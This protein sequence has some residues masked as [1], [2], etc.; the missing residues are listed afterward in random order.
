VV[1]FF[2]YC[3]NLTIGSSK[4]ATRR[5]TTLVYKNASSLPTN[6]LIKENQT[7]FTPDPPLV[8]FHNN[9]ANT[10]GGVLFAYNCTID[11][12]ITN[13]HFVQNHAL[14]AGGAMAIFHSKLNMNTIK[15]STVSSLNLFRGN[16]G[17]VV[18]HHSYIVSFPL[19]IRLH[20]PSLLVVLFRKLY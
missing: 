3:T 20:R 11:I 4:K 14:I 13:C 2:V 17:N 5:R 6:R 19:N 9:H 12:M 1:S 16:I 7:S 8:L 10:S 15:D 18:G